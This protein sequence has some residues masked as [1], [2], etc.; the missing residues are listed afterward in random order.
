MDI[1]RC[2]SSSKYFWMP[3]AFPISVPIRY[4][5]KKAPEELGDNHGASR[6]RETALIAVP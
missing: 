1:C 4:S 5:K 2:G 3:T 6:S